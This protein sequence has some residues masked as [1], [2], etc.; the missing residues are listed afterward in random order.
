MDDPKIGGVGGKAPHGGSL[1]ISGL[2]FGVEAWFEVLKCE[3]DRSLFRFYS[4]MNIM[5]I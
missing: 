4:A 2:V 1:D 5:H 3:N